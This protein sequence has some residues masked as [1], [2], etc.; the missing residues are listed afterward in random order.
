MGHHTKIMKNSRRPKQKTST[1]INKMEKFLYSLFIFTIVLCLIF[2]FLCNKFVDEY[3]KKY[4]YIFSN[5]S[6]KHGKAYRFVINF[7]I[8]FIDYYQ[9]IPI[10]LYVV[11]EIIK[12]YQ[13][14]LIRYDFEI[15]DLSID[16]PAE[17]R[18]IGL[19]E[20]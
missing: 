17:S 5:K 15:Y 12:I 1:M 9:I 7:L 13:S 4:D 2:S 16:K 19:I 18:E 3:G 8:F 20:E 10:S 11:M 14:I 6:L